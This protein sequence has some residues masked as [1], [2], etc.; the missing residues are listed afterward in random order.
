M[1][2]QGDVELI[3]SDVHNLFAKTLGRTSDFFIDIGPHTSAYWTR[4][5]KINQP[6]NIVMLKQRRPDRFFGYITQ[7]EIHS[8]GSLI[9]MHR[10][11]G[12]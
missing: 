10:K 3:W 6:I 8:G 11:H 5:I 9:K 2:L 4:D 7:I 1:Q 12:V